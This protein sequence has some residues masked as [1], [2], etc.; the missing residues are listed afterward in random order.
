MEDKKEWLEKLNWSLG[1]VLKG[2]LT[3]V[4]EGEIDVKGCWKIK[5]IDEKAELESKNGLERQRNKEKR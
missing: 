5:R 2:V 4:R 1:E 3:K